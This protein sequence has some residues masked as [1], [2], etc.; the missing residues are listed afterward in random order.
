MSVQVNLAGNS[1]NSKL[2]KNT[3]SPGNCIITNSIRLS[4]FFSGF[5]TTM[6]YQQHFV[7]VGSDEANSIQ[8]GR[9]KELTG[10][11]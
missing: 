4:S 11:F 5:V 7:F 6:K 9:V 3:P 8:Q 1:L 10:F 2:L